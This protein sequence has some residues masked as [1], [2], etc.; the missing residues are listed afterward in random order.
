MQKKIAFK[1]HSI[2]RLEFDG[3]MI[4]SIDYSYN[5]IP[6]SSQ[7]SLTLVL[8]DPKPSSGLLGHQEHTWYRSIYKPNTHMVAI[9]GCQ[10]DN[11]AEMKSIPVRDSFFFFIV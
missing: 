10:L 7:P 4:K 2:L 1:K 8:V 3:S 5:S 9:L 6:S 11:N